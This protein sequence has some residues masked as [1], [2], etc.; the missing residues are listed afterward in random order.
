MHSIKYGV[1]ILLVTLVIVPSALAQSEELEDPGITP[2]S[3]FYFLDKWGEGI[4]LFFTFGREAKAAKQVRL[5]EERLAEASEMADK[6]EDELAEEAIDKYGE[7]ISGAA[8]NLAAAARNGEDIEAALTDL[9]TKATSIHQ[10]VLAEVYTKVPEQA[11]PA[12]ER[13]M[14]QSAQGQEAALNALSGEQQQT[15]REQAAQQREA[16]EERLNQLRQQGAPI[17]TIPFGNESGSTPGAPAGVPGRGNTPSGLRTSPESSPANTGT[18]QN[19][20]RQDQVSR[21]ATPGRP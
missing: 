6:E 5:A 13:A 7:L 20:V 9:V 12:I 4:G 10:T 17:P 19:S 15:V 16:V 2:D 1:V 11:K 3:P 21:P 18:S 8:S 14:T